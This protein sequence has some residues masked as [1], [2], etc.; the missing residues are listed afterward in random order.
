MTLQSYICEEFDHPQENQAF[1][2]L[3]YA[4]SR[5]FSSD[6][7]VIGNIPIEH[8][9]RRAGQI[10]ALVLR[11]NSITIVD[12]KD[13]GGAVRVSENGE[14]HTS[15]GVRIAGGS[16]DANP[17]QQVLRYKNE[18]ADWLGTSGLLPSPNDPRHISGLVM[19]TR[20]MTVDGSAM[21][22]TTNKWFCAADELGAMDFLRDRASGHLNLS[23]DCMASIV[24]KIQAK[25]LLLPPT[26]L[27]VPSSA[28]QRA[29]QAGYFEAMQDA[30]DERQAQW[31]AAN[32]DRVRA[33]YEEACRGWAIHDALAAIRRNLERLQHEAAFVDDLVA[34]LDRALWHKSVP[35]SAVLQRYQPLTSVDLTLYLQHWCIEPNDHP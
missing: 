21:R 16:R 5:Y 31:W 33:E 8:S 14:W 25:P 6:A 23:A 28:V 2:K 11:P 24:A 19:F 17:F 9:P 29:R 1:R 22:E 26:E 10:D 20:P 35:L 32:G 4:G 3:C 18:L 12:F 30:E 13:V 34:D 27:L 7:T 15:E